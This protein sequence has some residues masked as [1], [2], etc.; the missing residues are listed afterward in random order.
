MIKTKRADLADAERISELL[1]ANTKER[2]GMLE[3]HWP[4]EVIRD[5]LCK[6][7]PIVVALDED[8]SL[9]GALLTQ[10]KAEGQA[11]PVRAMLAAW[12]GTPDGYIYGP[13]CIASEARGRGV[14]P[15]LYAKAREVHPGREAILFIRQDNQ[16]S[17]RAHRKLGMR[18]VSHYELDGVAFLVFSDGPT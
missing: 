6:N 17:I 13:V 15:A 1:T 8:G 5:R 14:L 11:P 16:P 4:L 3:G 10:E 7:Q 9:L 18:E 2:G 12:P